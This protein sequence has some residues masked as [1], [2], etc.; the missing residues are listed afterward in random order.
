MKQAHEMSFQEFAESANLSAG[1]NR[2]PQVGA[3]ADVVSYTVYMN[4]QTAEMLP[5]SAREHEFRDVLL[6]PL[7]E[8]LG[9]D[10]HSVRDNTKVAELL[11]L[12]HSYMTAVL[13]ASSV[14][15]QHSAG[16]L[17]DYELL[18]EK[19]MHPFI[20]AAIEKQRELGGLLRPV[21]Q[22]AEQTFGTAVSERAAA[23]VSRGA[24]VSQNEAFTVQDVGGGRVVAHENSRLEQLPAIGENVVVTYYRGKGQVIDNIESLTMS[25]PFVDPKTGDLAVG[26]HDEA[27]RYPKGLK[28]VVLFNSIASIAEFSIENGLGQDFVTK[29]MD[30]RAAIPKR[31]PAKPP[32]ALVGEPF[33]DVDSNAIA[34]Q[35]R[36]GAVTY[37]AVFG[38]PTEL[39]G[40]AVAMGASASFVETVNTLAPKA[41]LSLAVREV[42]SW[43]EA[44]A[45]AR[46][47][48]GDS[49]QRPNV[50]IGRYTGPV[51][52]VTELH[53]VQDLGRG[54]AMVHDK[55]ALDKIP[56]PGERLAIAYRSGRGEVTVRELS[57]ERGNGRA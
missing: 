34:F 49:A 29:A 2:W 11:A 42:Q 41:N 6:Y 7:T 55:R 32:R 35:Y 25:S 3:S 13:E 53:V 24:V 43:E 50:T 20:R 8:K 21:M 23:G 26:L 48:V 57:K 17:A 45:I 1:V 27:S 38:S 56:M 14:N 40:H 30:V 46:E 36:E 54:A 28:R 12:R 44:S 19:M 9:L 4:G 52:A 31:M 18:S 15:H 47:K 33:I 39:L 51:V 22:Q 16:T 5:E 10:P 37:T